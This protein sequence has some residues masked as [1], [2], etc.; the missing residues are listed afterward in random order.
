MVDVFLSDASATSLCCGKQKR[1]ITM[2]KYFQ[3][4]Q[5]FQ[6]MSYFH[7]YRWSIRDAHAGSKIVELSDNPTKNAHTDKF[8]DEKPVKWSILKKEITQ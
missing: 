6:Q 1:K 5:T 4:G 8:Y 7:S 2:K 3:K